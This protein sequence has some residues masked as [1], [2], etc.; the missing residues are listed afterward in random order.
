MLSLFE[1]T[2]CLLLV[3][4]TFLIIL[5]ICSAAIDPNRGYAAEN[6][7]VLWQAVHSGNVVVLIRHAIAPG[8]G[9]PVAFT[10]GDCL[11]QRNL[12]DT[13]RRQAQAIGARFRAN[14]IDKAQVFS[15]QWCRCLE[16]AE[17]LGLGTVIELPELNSFFQQYE[18]R[19][20]QTDKL[21][22]W[23]NGQSLDQ[24]TVLVTHQVNI[25][26]LTDI[27]PGSGEMVIVKRLD[28]G[29]LSVLGRIQTE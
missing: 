8:T 23:I 29:A 25:T 14:G 20:S 15:S 5:L 12:S 27:Y 10:I 2:P 11:T 4:Q 24:P 21:R 13:G 1:K 18:R 9:D 16:T 3:R 26:A 17:L 22:K 6:Q 19:D 28:S 7:T